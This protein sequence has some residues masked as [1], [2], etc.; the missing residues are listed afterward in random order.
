MMM[1]RMLTSPKLD[2]NRGARCAL[3]AEYGIFSLASN[4]IPRVY[5]HDGDNINERERDGL[6]A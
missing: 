2:L 6:D 5:D 3:L 4:A 1:V